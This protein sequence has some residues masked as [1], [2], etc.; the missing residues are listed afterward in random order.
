VYREQTAPLIDHYR[1]RNLL[2]EVDGRGSVEEVERR[3]QEA[4]VA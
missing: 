2:V 3:I 1:A 4:L